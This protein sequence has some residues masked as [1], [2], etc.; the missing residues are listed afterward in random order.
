MTPHPPAPDGLV[1]PTPAEAAPVTVPGA[2]APPPQEAVEAEHEMTEET[3][4][5]P[6]LAASEAAE[7]V[8]TVEDEVEEDVPFAPPLELIDETVSDEDLKFDW[9][10]L[11]VQVNREDSIKDALWRRV[12]M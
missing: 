6:P 9:F 5:R 3:Q 4:S 8:E 11:K 1:P 10:I 12:K 2:P 7:P